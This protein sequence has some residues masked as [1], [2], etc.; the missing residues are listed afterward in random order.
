MIY[1]VL[2]FLGYSKITTTPIY[3]IVIERKVSVDFNILKE[4][5]NN[6]N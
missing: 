1:K 2:W 3:A 5:L 6:K 4:K